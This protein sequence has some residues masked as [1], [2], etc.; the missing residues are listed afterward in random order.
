[1]NR[2]HIIFIALSLIYLATVYKCTRDSMEVDCDY[3]QYLE[4]GDYE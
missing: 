3:G 2:Y 4:D 1:M